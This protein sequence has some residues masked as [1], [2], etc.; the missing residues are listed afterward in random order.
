[1]KWA[2][3]IMDNIIVSDTGLVKN[4]ISGLVRKQYISKRSGYY[5]V[6]VLVNGRYR[7]QRVHRLVAFAFIPNPNQYGDVNHKDGNKLN[8]CVSNLEWCTRSQN[9]QHAFNTGL[10]QRKSV[11][12][13]KE[14]KGNYKRSKA[15]IQFSK[16]GQFINAFSSV[17]EAAFMTGI[18]LPNICSVCCGR[19]SYAGD[20]KWEY[21]A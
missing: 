5:Y 3:T 9:I 18:R 20:Y 17:T 11:Y 19:R 10:R 14:F 15:V 1:M 6:S 12:S 8:N 21:A 16:T 13:P 4:A 7:P 2:K